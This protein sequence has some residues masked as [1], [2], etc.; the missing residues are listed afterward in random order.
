MHINRIWAFCFPEFGHLNLHT[1]LK[2]LLDM[3]LLTNCY[4]NANIIIKL[5]KINH[6]FQVYSLP[7]QYNPYKVDLG[8]DVSFVLKADVI[9]VEGIGF[10]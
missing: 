9:L 1:S 3:R 2:K 4:L 10:N 6:V 8:D 5:T 7:S